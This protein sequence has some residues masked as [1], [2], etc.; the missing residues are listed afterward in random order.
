[1][2]F[3]ILTKRVAC[4]AKAC[5][6][7]CTSSREKMM[8]LLR[9]AA[10]ASAALAAALSTAA[11]APAPHADASAVG[12]K[13][14]GFYAAGAPRTRLAPLAMET[15]FDVVV[16]GGGIIGLAT[17][18]EL[19]ARYPRKRV[20][21]IEKEPE[22]ARHQTGHNSGVIHAGMYYVP[23]TTMA[24]TCVRGAELMYKYCADKQLPTD[25]VGK[26]IVAS[27]P[28]EHAQVQLLFERG[29]ANGVK[30][31]KVLTGAETAAL[32]PAVSAAHSALWSPNTGITDYGLVAKS[33][34]ADVIDSGRGDVKL[35]FAV[36]GFEED[37]AAG[38]VVIRGVEPGQV[39]PVKT[40]TAA[41][42]IT[43]A[44]VHS[45]RISVLAGGKA[46]PKVVTFR[47]TYWQ[48][49]PAFKD[50]VKTN[51]YPVPT[52]GGIPVGVHFTPT[53]NER[54][55]HNMI[56][57]P[58]ACLSFSREGY[59]MSDVRARCAPRDPPLPPPLL[60]LLTRAPA[61]SPSR[62]WQINFSDIL[63]F[64]TNGAF[65]SFAFKNPVLSVNELWKDVNKAAFL[66]DAQKL[67]PSVT[68]DMV[69]PSFTGVMAQVFEADGT[70]A[71]DYIFEPGCLNGKVFNLRNAPS[72]ACTASLAI[73]ENVVARAAETFGWKP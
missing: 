14:R 58:G 69:E 68:E 49:K 20:A 32:E 21:V 43:C 22:V 11:A 27:T 73:A 29:T 57:G 3:A 54:R 38:R 26:L 53:V 72:P 23:G 5:T 55:G 70:A 67:V 9:P 30:G 12:T 42:V 15:D 31:L 61:V 35:S 51:V 45:D 36:T 60:T 39:G 2:T 8:R 1:M 34:A 48:M 62:R 25:R 46:E 17:A 10:A 56:I 52:G 44:G 18:R 65:W 47:G 24:K 28:A 19:L 40:V 7:S 41:H 13:N 16:V 37:A 71:K 6:S 33:L 4:Y 59:K 64:I 63:G 66:R 50:I